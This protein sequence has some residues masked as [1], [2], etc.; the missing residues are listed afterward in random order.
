MKFGAGEFNE[1]CQHIPFFL[2]QTTVN[3]RRRGADTRFAFCL[4]RASVFLALCL[5][6]KQKRIVRSFD[7]L[8]FVAAYLNGGNWVLSWII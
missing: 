8:A 6:I 1:I 2:S 3:V 5:I 4:Q 7:F